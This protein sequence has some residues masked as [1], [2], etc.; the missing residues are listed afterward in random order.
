M[1]IVYE[2]NPFRGC[3]GRLVRVFW[4]EREPW[5][6]AALSTGE[7]VAVPWSWTNL[8]H[9]VAPDPGDVTD[10]LM[11]SPKGLLDLIGCLR[12]LGLSPQPRDGRRA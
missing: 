1:T 10:G 5:V 2:E 6:L 12:R 11:L 4:R 3:S 8:S 7:N 9:P